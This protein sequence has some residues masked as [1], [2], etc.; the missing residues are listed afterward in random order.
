MKLSECERILIVKPSSLGDIIHAIPAVEAIHRAAPSAKIDWIANTEWVPLLEG[1]PFL[2]NVIPFPRREFRG[3]SGLF[4]AKR[5]IG[6]KVAPN[7]YDLAL[8]FQGLLRSAMIAK[9]SKARETVGFENAREGA[10]HFYNHRVRVGDCSAIHAVDRNLL[11]A[12]AFG[13]NISEPSFT[14]PEGDSLSVPVP[15]NAILL[16]PF[17]RGAGKSL[18]ETEVCELCE[19]LAP[20][21]VILAGFPEQSISRKWPDNVRDLLGATT[22]PQLIHLIRETA[23]TVSVDSG[24]MHLAAALSDNVLSLH[25]WSNP[26]M[27]GPWRPNSYIFRDSQIVRVTDLGPNQFPERRDLKAA[28]ASRERLFSES[29]IAAIAEFLKKR[30][31]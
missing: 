13:A 11:I 10:S 27:V 18:S 3:V 15:E 14:L 7:G 19:K 2:D 24:P 22:L 9:L 26:E 8:D 25:T 20:H 4:Q 6:E 17:S 23:W 29:D 30:L 28:F 1:I 5:W 12:D 31:P 16:H 21:P